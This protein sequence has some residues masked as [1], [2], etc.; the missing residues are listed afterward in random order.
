MCTPVA[1]DCGEEEGCEVDGDSG[2]EAAAG[3]WCCCCCR[4]CPSPCPCPSP[5]LKLRLMEGEGMIQLSLD[6]LSWS[7]LLAE[8]LLAKFGCTLFG[9]SYLL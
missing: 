2:A 7:A 8:C 4:P 6:R 1:P 5:M 3:A 9:P